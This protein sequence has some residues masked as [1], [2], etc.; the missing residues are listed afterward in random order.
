MSKYFLLTS[1]ILLLLMIVPKLTLT[2]SGHTPLRLLHLLGLVVTR[3]EA[4]S[5]IKVLEVRCGWRAYGVEIADRVMA[6]GHA[7]HS[8][9]C[10]DFQ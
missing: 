1:V 10:G 9:A 4:L 8:G 7:S 5:R 3:L 6:E 2:L